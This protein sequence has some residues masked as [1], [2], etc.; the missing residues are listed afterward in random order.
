MLTTS[1]LKKGTRVELDGE[2]YAVVESSTQS[3]GG[4]GGNTLVRV[5]LR[6]IR[7]GAQVDR[8]F[9]GGDKLKAPDFVIQP[10]QY[11]FDENG[12]VYYFMDLDTFEQFPLNRDDIAYELGFIR[13]ND[14]VRALLFNGQCIGI[15]LPH[16]VELAVTDTI[17]GFKGDTV[18]AATKPATL[19]T[20]L[21]I[22]VPMFV[23]VGQ[24]LV[25]DTREARYVRRA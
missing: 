16:T 2:P 24:T 21:E 18:N 8:T 14:E 11:L 17:P 6:N 10:A 9:K 22:Q 3:A 23:E 4:R 13:P 7:T 5:R 1:D 12:E 25:I 15:E 19:E 20:G